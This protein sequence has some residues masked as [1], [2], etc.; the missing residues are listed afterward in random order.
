MEWGSNSF[1]MAIPGTNKRASMSRRHAERRRQNDRCATVGGSGRRATKNKRTCSD[2]GCWRRRRRGRY[3]EDVERRGL[4]GGKTDLRIAVLAHVE[5]APTV[6]GPML[7]S[8]NLPLSWLAQIRAPSRK[9]FS[10]QLVCPGIP[11]FGSSSRL[12]PAPLCRG[13]DR[14]SKCPRPSLPIQ[15]CPLPVV[16]PAL[17]IPLLFCSSSPFSTTTTSTTATTQ[18]ATR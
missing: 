1:E 6:R 16:P 7:L 5:S 10:L 4:V 2:G 9:H 3:D 13:P 11:L 14:A 15:P 12:G 18:S 8:L 17:N